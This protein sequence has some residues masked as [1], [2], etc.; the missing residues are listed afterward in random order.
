MFF[1]AQLIRAAVR[2]AVYYL[3]VRFLIED[4]ERF[5][6]WFYGISFVD[7]IWLTIVVAIWLIFDSHIQQHTEAK[8]AELL[9]LIE[10][11]QKELDDE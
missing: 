8:R 4:L 11:K 9:E 7:G 10:E 6:N 2:V 1:I 5:L 3:I